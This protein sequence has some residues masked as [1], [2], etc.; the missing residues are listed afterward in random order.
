MVKRSKEKDFISWNLLFWSKENGFKLETEYVFHPTRKWRFDWY[1]EGY[2]D[3][4]VIQVGVEYNGIIAPRSRH[5]TISGYSADLDK[6]N[7]AMG[8][9]MRVLQFSP[10]NY[11]KLISE[12][13]KML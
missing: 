5:L 4:M 1:L 13:N 11:T 3:G 8:L 7:A 2:K 12:L 6:I 10:L 9:G